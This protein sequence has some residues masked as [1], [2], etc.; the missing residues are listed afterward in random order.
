MQDHQV[1]H[2]AGHHFIGAAHDAN[3]REVH[4]WQTRG[5]IVDAAGLTDILNGLFSF[6][7]AM[8]AKDYARAIVSNS[9]SQGINCAGAVASQEEYLN[10]TRQHFECIHLG[11]N[12]ERARC[13]EHGDYVL[14]SVQDA[15][16]GWRS[17][18]GV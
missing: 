13:N 12:R 11:G 18:A 10:A 14:P 16:A 1:A 7:Y 17:C 6:P 9:V 15:W 5:V 2:A 3:G 8:K 4:I